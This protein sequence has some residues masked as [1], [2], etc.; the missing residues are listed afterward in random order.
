M[1]FN[2]TLAA[3][4][5]Q[6]WKFYAIDYKRLK[7]SLKSKTPPPPPGSIG[8]ASFD[9]ILDESVEKLL[10]FYS[11]KEAEVLKYEKT[12]RERLN[13]LE[14]SEGTSSLS[15]RTSR[16]G[17]SGMVS[18][19]SD[20]S[21]AAATLAATKEVLIQNTSSSSEDE[22]ELV[23][24]STSPSEE[25]PSTSS[26]VSSPA[27]GITRSVSL[28]DLC[29]QTADNEHFKDYI[30]SIKS[31]RT[32]ERELNLLLDFTTLNHTGFR[33]ILKK[34]DKV[35]G[36]TTQEQKLAEIERK[37]PFLVDGGALRS[38]H[39]K[40]LKMIDATVA[41][42]PLLPSGWSDRKVYTIGCFDLFHRGHANVLM[43]LREFGHFIVAGIHDDESYFKL[44]K[45]YPI[46]NLTTRMENVKPF[47]DMIYVIPSTDP[48]P[49]IKNAVSAQD[50]DAGLCCYARGDDMLNFPSRDW[51]ESVMPVHFLPR[52]EGCSSSLIRTIYHATDSATREKAAFAKTRYDGKPVDEN[53]EVIK[54]TG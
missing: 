41:L 44:K 29:R 47:V 46:D 49:F 48:L 32:F 25:S 15:R 2:K 20:L 42:K 24:I 22:D 34:Q 21:L 53:G 36:T 40:V 43:S 14:V 19:P 10:K 5:Q 31:L 38:L 54:T 45:K 18:C 16:N 11:S 6:E 4:V 8:G 35:M 12:L 27:M 33:K 30:Y 51:V 26:R 28:K 1:K 17:L 37:L 9:A 3:N 50:I 39:A 7:Q 13:K 52:T 23:D